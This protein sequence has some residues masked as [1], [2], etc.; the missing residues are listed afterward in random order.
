MPLQRHFQEHV[1][2]SKIFKEKK[3]KTTQTHAIIVWDNEVPMHSIYFGIAKS[4]DLV[5]NMP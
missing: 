4:T 3:N 5:N 1:M 2:I